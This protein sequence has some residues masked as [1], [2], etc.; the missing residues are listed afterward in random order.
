MGYLT[1][2]NLNIKMSASQVGA[3]TRVAKTEDGVSADAMGMIGWG[4]YGGINIFNFLY[5]A[6]LYYKRYIVG[7]YSW[8]GLSFKTIWGA[9]TWFRTMLHVV[10]SAAMMFL[11]CLTFLPW[12]GFWY[13]FY[14]FGVYFFTGYYLVK[15]GLFIL[16]Q[17]VA[18][19]GDDYAKSYKYYDYFQEQLGMGHEQGHD[20][21][22]LQWEEYKLEAANVMAVLVAG[23]MFSAGMKFWYFN[24]DA[25]FKE[26]TDVTKKTEEKKEKV[27][28]TSK[29]IMNVSDVLFHDLF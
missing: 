4:V 20:A 3:M 22:E 7:N 13:A 2:I 19:L 21:E 10:M 24:E 17:C 26:T 12:S 28:E 8:D 15:T 5:F 29:K 9:S 6:D 14:Y 23:P 18:L 11:W 16:L 27:T 1:Y 25:K